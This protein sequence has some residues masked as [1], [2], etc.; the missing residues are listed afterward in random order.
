MCIGRLDLVWWLGYNR[1]R[2]KRVFWLLET[3]LYFD[4]VQHVLGS[5]QKHF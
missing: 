5:I 2:L 4:S 3:K 1:S